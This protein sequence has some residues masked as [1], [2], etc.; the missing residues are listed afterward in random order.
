MRHTPT[1][2]QEDSKRSVL[3]G[4]HTKISAYA[5]AS[6]TTSLIY[7]SE[8]L[9]GE[10]GKYLSFNSSIAK[11]A[12][13]QFPKWVECRTTH[14][15]AFHAVGKAYVNAGRKIPDKNNRRLRTYEVANILKVSDGYRGQ[16]AKVSRNGLTYMALQ[17]VVRFCYSAD[18]EI[19]WQHFPWQRTMATWPEQEL[20]DVR[21]LVIHYAQMAW[22]D[23]MNK[24]GVLSYEHDYYLKQFQLSKPH[25]RVDFLMMDEGQ[26]T[27]PATLDIFTSQGDHA[28]LI[29]VGDSY[30]QIYAWRG[31]VDAM[32]SFEA[33]NT[34]YL[35]KSFR[36]GEAVA[37]EANKWLTLLGAP[38]P[39]VGFEK[40]ESEVKHLENP[41]AVL[42]RTNAQVIAETLHYQE[43]GKKVYVQGGTKDIKDFAEAAQQLMAGQPVEHAELIGFENWD[44]VKEYAAGDDGAKDLRI[45]VKLVDEY[46]VE[47]ILNIATTAVT[48][49]EYADVTTSTAHKAKGQEYEAVR[50]APDFMEPEP[51]K[52]GNEPKLNEAEG[53]LAYV[54]VTRAK[55]FLDCEALGWVN[56][57]VTRLQNTN[58]ARNEVVEQE[59]FAPLSTNKEINE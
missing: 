52:D 38:H 47:K 22:R 49:R 37:N 40:L 18:M 2:E 17:T 8:S 56:D 48:K 26:D 34:C 57:W 53:K 9:K 10:K 24:N 35:T 27:N 15:L 33:V 4:E 39:L 6:K 32:N 25:I 44:E 30:Q 43:K 31:A 41:T 45:F 46:G 36:F 54:A 50:I 12:A 19:G 59:E 28:Q 16:I 55:R 42:C 51:D 3:E 14:S 1:Q 58:G 5:G 29:M 7:I 20:G 23:I 13:T 11:E 21:A